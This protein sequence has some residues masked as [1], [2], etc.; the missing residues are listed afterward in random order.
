MFIKSIHIDSFGGLSGK[1]FDF[2]RALN[3]I[4]GNNESGK[5]T[6]LSFIKFILYGAQN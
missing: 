1:D 3:I 2:S 6:L 4:E 5:S